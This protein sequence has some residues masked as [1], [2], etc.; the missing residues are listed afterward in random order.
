M[1]TPDALHQVLGVDGDQMDKLWAKSKDAGNL[2]K[3]GGG[4]YAGKVEA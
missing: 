2:V 4:F 1:H 3:F